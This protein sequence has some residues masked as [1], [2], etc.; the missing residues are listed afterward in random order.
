MINLTIIILLL[1]LTR[2]GYNK[3]S[4]G[5]ANWLLHEVTNYRLVS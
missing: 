3:S 5:V 1:A 4:L 2:A